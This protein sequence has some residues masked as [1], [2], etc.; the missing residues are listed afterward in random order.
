MQDRP[1]ANELL[2]AIQDF[3]IKEIMP[4]VK[5]DDS[6]SFKTLISWN[7]LGV[8]SREIKNEEPNLLEE[9]TSLVKILGNRFIYES[10]NF[11][12]LDESVQFFES[13]NL[14]IKKAI[15]AEGNKLLTDYIIQNNVLPSQSIILN[16]IRETLKNK[17]QIS[18][19]R[20][21]L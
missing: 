5:E 18:N 8:I 4:K 19:P 10:R 2:E 7:M 12:N 6:L 9:F 17:L 16:H 21:A 11:S 13:S 15:L 3:L 14:K 20:Y 1:N